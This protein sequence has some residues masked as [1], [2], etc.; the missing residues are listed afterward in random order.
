M[1]RHPHVHQ[2]SRSFRYALLTILAV[3]GLAAS[4]IPAASS[5]QVLTSS[6]ISYQLFNAIG[7][8]TVMEFLS[9]NSVLH[10][11]TGD[12]AGVEGPNAFG[13]ELRQSFSRLEFTTT[14]IESV[15][16]LLIVKF[17]MTGVHTRAFNDLEAFCARINV[18]GIAVMRIAETMVVVE[19]PFSGTLGQYMG[20]N[21]EVQS[22]VVEQW[23]NYD[24][25]VIDGQIA[26]FNDIQPHLR[27]G[28][29]DWTPV[30]P[31]QVASPADAL[32]PTTDEPVQDSHP[33]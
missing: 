1:T 8:G 32:P 28:C 31:V 9:A 14:S 2:V 4:L 16:Q 30:S 11:P 27:P 10:T 13:D 33:Y 21:V 15:E 18:P 5:A 12:Y 24:E 7:A 3:I 23:I 22:R 29:A 25:A 19:D 6:P 26:V 20:P 17:T